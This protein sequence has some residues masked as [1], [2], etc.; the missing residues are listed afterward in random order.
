MVPFLTEKEKWLYTILESVPNGII[1][2]DAQGKIALCNS[3]AERMFG[4]TPGELINQ[5]VE[6]LVPPH[7]RDVHP[8]LRQVFHSHP[9]KR[10]M[11]AGRDLAG[12]TKDGREI[13]VEIGLNPVSSSDG[14]FVLAS[15]VNITERKRNEQQLLEAYAELQRRNQ[16]MERFIYMIS[17]DLR[18]PM[19]ATLGLVELI[20]SDIEERNFA[21]VADALSRIEGA[22]ERMRQLIDDLLELSRA[23]RMELKRETVDMNR[24]M[25][26]IVDSVSALAQKRGARISVH[27]RLP[28]IDADHNRI[29]QIFEN[30]L[31]N[32]LKYGTSGPDPS[33]QIFAKETGEEVRFCIADNGQGIAKEYHQKVFELF[34]RLDNSQHGTGIGLAIVARI[35]ELH[36]GRVWVESEPGHGAAFWVALPKSG[37]P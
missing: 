11:G 10:Q 33:I 5:S 7:S 34:Q 24:L 26:G 3:E 20:R 9:L 32:A 4:Y 25:A 6:V 30:L 35:A 17:H 8:S 29:R 21:D 16:E 27:G 37:K 2:V 13:P 12:F 1:L 14:D 15:I 22:S 18:S 23:G 31:I 28:A 19:V 36:G